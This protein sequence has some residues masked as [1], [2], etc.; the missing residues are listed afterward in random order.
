MDPPLPNPSIEF[1]EASPK[2][3][4]VTSLPSVNAYA[5]RKSQ[6][7]KSTLKPTSRRPSILKSARD[8]ADN[9]M[10]SSIRFLE[11]DADSTHSL[12]QD[13][14]TLEL[15]RKSQYRWT[16]S[17]TDTEAEMKYQRFIVHKSEWFWK[18]TI[19]LILVFYLAFY[20]FT[21]VSYPRQAQIWR[22]GYR[23]KVIDPSVMAANMVENCPV[24]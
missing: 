6:G 11:V 23:V 14:K 9:L 16:L 19:A 13:E 7:T 17:F 22:D 18:A 21:L 2:P 4:L 3:S 12:I 1:N 24:G 5:K 15:L 8:V 10:K 20:V